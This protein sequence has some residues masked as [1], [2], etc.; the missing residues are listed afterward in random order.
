MRVDQ[1]PARTPAQITSIAW[2]TLDV[3]SQQRLQE[4]GI[5]EGVTVELMH[6]A[7]LG[8]DP[9]ALRI[10]RMMVAMRR[11]HAAAIRVSVNPTS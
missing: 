6:K 10:G 3:S 5:D 1:L 2:D 8:G 4:F 11:V 7:P 9:L